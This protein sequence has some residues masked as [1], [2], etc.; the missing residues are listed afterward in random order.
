[1]KRFCR[2]PLFFPNAF[3]RFHRFT[4]ILTRGRDAGLFEAIQQPRFIK[5]PVEGVPPSWTV[6][7][8]S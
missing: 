6:G 2:P 8:L 7:R 5:P 4:V 1:M 3:R